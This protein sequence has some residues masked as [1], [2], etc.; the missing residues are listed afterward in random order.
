MFNMDSIKLTL[1]LYTFVVFSVNKCRNHLHKL[2]ANYSTWNWKDVSHD[3]R[4]EIRLHLVTES[5]ILLVDHIGFGWTV[6]Q[7]FKKRFHKSRI[8]YYSNTSSCVTHQLLYDSAVKQILESGD[9]SQNPGPVKWPC[10]VCGKAVAKHHRA[11]QCYQCDK[12]CHIGERCGNIKP[13][14]YQ[15]LIKDVS[16]SLKWYCPMCMNT[17]RCI[18]EDRTRPGPKSTRQRSQGPAN[19]QN[20]GESCKEDH[21][22]NT[23]EKLKANK[24]NISMAHINIDGLLHKMAERR[25]RQKSDYDKVSELWGG[26][27]I[28]YKENLKV[29]SQL[30]RYGTNM[31]AIWIEII[32]HSQRL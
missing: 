1:L 15:K 25:D 28:Y 6:K 10:C 12:W 17:Q 30:D 27:V 20:E 13:I 21:T 11:V 31:E 16:N 8:S 29:I 26:V 22:A 5:S 18:Q 4:D 2:K 32:S 23:K 7:G 14:D 24:N 19:R 3:G 9:V